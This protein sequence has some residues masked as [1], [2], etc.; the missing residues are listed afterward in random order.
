MMCR[1]WKDI[2]E[3]GVVISPLMRASVA[4]GRGGG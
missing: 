4:E 1:V 2:L 3:T